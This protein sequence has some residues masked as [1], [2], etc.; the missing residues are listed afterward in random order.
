MA[1]PQSVREKVVSMIKSGE[2]TRKEVM[3]Q[4]GIGQTTIGNWLREEN[5]L[6]RE[7]QRLKQENKELLALVG[8]LSL[9]TA[10]SKKN[11]LAEGMSTKTKDSDDN[12]EDT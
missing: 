11:Q 8:K 3:S 12:V 1:I 7:N 9:E 6:V 4:F 2:V 10:R 5:P